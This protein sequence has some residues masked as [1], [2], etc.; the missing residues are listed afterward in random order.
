MPS[1]QHLNKSGQA[2]QPNLDDWQKMKYLLCGVLLIIKFLTYGD[3]E[4]ESALEKENLTTKQ[5]LEE[6]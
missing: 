2:T 1:P 5:W 3:L 6:I 4:L